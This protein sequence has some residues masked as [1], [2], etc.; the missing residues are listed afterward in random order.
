MFLFF[1]F[2]SLNVVLRSYGCRGDSNNAAEMEHSETVSQS[3]F[4][5]AT[6]LLRVEGKAREQVGDDEANGADEVGVGLDPALKS[7]LMGTAS[8]KQSCFAKTHENQGPQLGARKEV[9]HEDSTFE[10]STSCSEE[11]PYFNFQNQTWERDDS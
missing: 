4:R 1:L 3:D 7:F 8:Q 10:E 11:S 2:S 6:V 5:R 9:Y